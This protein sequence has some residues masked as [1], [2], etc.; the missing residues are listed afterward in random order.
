MSK[1]LNIK[2]YKKLCFLLAF[3]ILN[4][5]VDSPDTHNYRLS[6]NLLI[7]DQESILEILIE[8]VFKFDNAIVEYDED[9]TEA[10]FKKDKNNIDF[11]ILHL[12]HS[13]HIEIDRYDNN[14]FSSVNR[15]IRNVYFKIPSPPPDSLI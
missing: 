10:S 9:D 5:S 13:A 4:L 3:Y 2:L 7:N 6:D 1:K 12:K 15:K 8:K 14:N 11:Y